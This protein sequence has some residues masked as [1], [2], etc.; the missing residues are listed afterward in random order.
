M[1]TAKPT[2]AAENICQPAQ[3]KAGGSRLLSVPSDI[4]IPEL[5]NGVKIYDYKKGTDDIYSGK[6]IKFSLKDSD[7]MSTVESG[8]METAQR[9]VDE[10]AND[11]GY[12]IKAY[13][14]TPND[15][16]TVFDKNRIGKGNDQYGAGFYFASNEEASKSYGN[17]VIPSFLSI[18]KPVKLDRSSTDGA[19][20]INGGY[21]YLLTEE[22]AY[23]VIK[24]LPN[25]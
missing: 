6:D 25:I 21:D 1:S 7:Y 4:S 23:E 13:H 5:V 8:D 16:F 2:R 22:Q 24:R 20:L 18:N 10:K 11:S 17:R 3:Q 15:G 14:G 12:T 9:M 19:N